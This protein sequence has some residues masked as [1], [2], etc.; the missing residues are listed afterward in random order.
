M[1]LKI[2]LALTVCATLLMTSCKKGDTGPIGPKGDTGATGTKGDPGSNGTNAN[3]IYSDWIPVN[4]VKLTDDPENLYQHS[5][6]CQQI[7]SAPKLSSEIVNKGQM[8]LFHKNALGD[9]VTL[10]N[11]SFVLDRYEDNDQNPHSMTYQV[12]SVYSTGNITIYAALLDSYIAVLDNINK[13]GSAFRYVLIPG[14]TGSG[15]IASG[16][17]AGHTIE[18]LK[19]M[20]Y[21]EVTKLLGIR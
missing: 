6:K 10:S 2:C 21:A 16:P 13:N 4:Y 20:S 8:L 17:A 1:K 19:K 5:F 9:I 15:R 12:L 11:G 7:I 3:V 14:V 18:E